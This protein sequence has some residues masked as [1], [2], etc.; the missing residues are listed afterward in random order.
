L[1]VRAESQQ[2]DRVIDAFSE[3]W[4]ECNQNH[5]FR[6]RGETYPKLI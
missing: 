1:V 5:G 4:C 2:L 6:D 3:R